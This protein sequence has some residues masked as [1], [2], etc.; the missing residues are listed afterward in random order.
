MPA[1]ELARSSFEGEEVLGTAAASRLRERLAE[2]PTWD[3]RFRVFAEERHVLTPRTRGRGPRHE[4]VEAWRL[5]WMSRGQLRIEELAERVFLS[6]RRL[7]TLFVQELGCSPKEVAQTMRFTHAVARIG[8]GV[9]AGR[10]DL[11]ATAAECGYA[12]QSHLAREFR[13]LAGIS[14]SAWIAEEFPNIQ[15]GGH[16]YTREWET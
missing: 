4:V 12:D 15:D 10:L 1:A 6:R 13:R 5:L 11:A 16:R 3:E 9:R 8:R 14:P 7:F 2:T